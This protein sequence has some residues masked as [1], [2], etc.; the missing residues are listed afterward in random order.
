MAYPDELPIKELTLP[1]LCERMNKVWND[2]H[3]M[4]IGDALF[5]QEFE[6][7]ENFSALM[8]EFSRRMR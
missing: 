6:M 3:D 8:D 2:V 1:Q 4:A 7:L 5:P